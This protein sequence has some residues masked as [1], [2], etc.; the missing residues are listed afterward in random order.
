[1][2]V[3]SYPCTSRRRSPRLRSPPRSDKTKISSYGEA[4]QNGIL[5]EVIV[6]SVFRRSHQEEV[7]KLAGR[8]SHLID[9][10]VF[11]N[12]YRIFRVRRVSCKDSSDLSGRH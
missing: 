10:E 7:R 2:T 9:R 8:S 12:R 3:P 5:Q 11:N 6:S 4:A 1:M